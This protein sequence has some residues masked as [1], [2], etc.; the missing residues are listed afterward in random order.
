[1]TSDTSGRWLY[2]ILS[3]DRVVQ[4][5][6]SDDWYFAH[7]SAWED[8]YERRDTS[9]LGGR[10]RAQCWCR[11]GVSDAMWRI[12]S[13]DKLGVRIRVSASRLKDSLKAA[14]TDQGFR[15]RV[16][17]VKYLNQLEELAYAS[18][19]ITHDPESQQSFK[20]ASDYLFRKRLA[21]AHEEESNHPPAKPGAF[22]M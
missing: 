15:H 19:P 5:L 16:E 17:T 8:P 9:I 7:P 10:L 21:F 11:N 2:R 18:P 13:P 14:A 6:R 22:G 4:I 3:F 12:Y 20:D 1:M